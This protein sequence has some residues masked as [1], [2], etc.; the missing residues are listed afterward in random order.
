GA[1]APVGVA[2]LG[3]DEA[4]HP[5]LGAA[6]TLP[7]PGAGLFTGRLT[8]AAQPWLLDHTVGGALIAP[9]AAIVELALW[10]A[11]WVAGQTAAAH[12]FDGASPSNGL[13][14]AE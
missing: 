5:L 13:R 3:L 10:T 14:V 7:E 4:S 9:G 8:A 1:A 12:P 2:G 11:R 6:A